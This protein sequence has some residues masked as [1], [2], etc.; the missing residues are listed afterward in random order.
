MTLEEVAATNEAQLA[1]HFVNAYTVPDLNHM[2]IAEDTHQMDLCPSNFPEASQ[3]GCLSS[4]AN[5]AGYKSC[6]WSELLGKI[7]R[8]MTGLRY[9][10]LQKFWFFGAGVAGFAAIVLQTLGN[11]EYDVRPETKEQ[12]DES[13]EA[14]LISRGADEVKVKNMRWMYALRNFCEAE[15]NL[16]RR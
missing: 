13:L 15:K 2:F 8:L 7:S 9:D 4:Q 1:F 14:I 3:N 12:V 16:Y 5:L 11:V 10:H 6:F